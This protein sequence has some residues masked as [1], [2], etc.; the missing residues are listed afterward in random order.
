MDWKEK[1]T[2]LNSISFDTISKAKAIHHEINVWR[3]WDGN[4]HT[5]RLELRYRKG[6]SSWLTLIWFVGHT[7]KMETKDIN[8]D[9]NPELLVTY[10]CG[11]HT[12]VINIFRV[13]Y[14]GFL[15]HIPG[16]EIG[17]DFCSINVEDRDGDG[18]CEVYAKNKNW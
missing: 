1:R 16:S 5:E 15:E 11:A 12:K 3:I 7:V 18:K 10:H 17:S 9:G 2:P 8:G 13:G 14:S 6:R 4:E